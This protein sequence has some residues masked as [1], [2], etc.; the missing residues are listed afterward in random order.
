MVGGKV[1]L[2]ISDL[3][4]SGLIFGLSIFIKMKN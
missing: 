2:Q 1:Y 4:F 3:F